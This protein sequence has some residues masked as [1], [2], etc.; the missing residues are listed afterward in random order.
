MTSRWIAYGAIFGGVVLTVA[1]VIGG[2]DN[3]RTV[4]AEFSN[5]RG[6][7][8]NNDVRVNGAPAGKVSDVELT[9]RGTAMV[10]MELKNGIPAPRRD[11]TAA[12]RPVDLLGDIYLSYS[13]G[14]DQRPPQGPIPLSNTTNVPRLADVLRAF[15]PAARAGLQALIIE[16]SAG[17][18]HRG[19]DLNRAAVEL[20]PALAAVQRLTSELGSQNAHL[21]NLVVDGQRLAR[22]LAA[23]R[24]D[25][26][27][28]VTSFAGALDELAQHAP[29]LSRGLDRLAPALSQLRTT[30]GELTQAASAARPL[31]AQVDAAAPNLATAMGQLVPFLR[32]VRDVS[33]TVRPT[34]RSVRRLLDRGTS[35]FPELNAGLAA[36]QDNAS[37]IDRATETL[38]QMA[39][40]TSQALFANVASETDEPGNQLLDP[41]ADPLRHYWRG[42]AVL[43]CQ[44][45]GVRTSPGCLDDFV[46]AQQRQLRTSKSPPS[47]KAVAKRPLRPV[48]AAVAPPSLAQPAND[49]TKPVATAVKKL[50]DGPASPAQSVKSLLDYLLGN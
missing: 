10:T 27:R 12:V 40:A 8:K 48:P 13:P 18:E 15:Q 6:L 43:S 26:G 30:S 19:V 2:S 41:N 9:S 32:A 22:Q 28:L 47:R 21:S 49:L 20:R 44:S 5:V 50:L 36:L 23:G 46:R 14:H 45:F 39:P 25:L 29:N 16:L 34:L 7:L 35:T 1:L 31:A 24:D 37:P 17:L 4:H 3:G 11:A 42:A 38:R 33:P